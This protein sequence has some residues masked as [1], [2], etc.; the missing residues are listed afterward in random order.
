VKLTAASDL[1]AVLRAELLLAR[2]PDKAGPMQAY[3]KSAMPYLGIQTPELRAICTRLF[4]AHPIETPV[5]W[6]STCL[7]IWRE[8]RFREERY[9]AIGLTGFRLYRS[10]QTLETLAMYEEMIVTGAWWDFVDAIASKRLGALLRAY[11]GRMRTQMLKWSRCGD[12]WKR[13]S[14]ILCQLGF[15]GETDL[16]LLYA[17]IEP[18]LSSS[19]L[20]GEFFLQ[21]AIGWA[22]RQYAWTDAREVARY[23]RE[24]QGELSPL[25]KREA[26]KN[27]G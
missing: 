4:A 20:S 27:I 8:A 3:M 23:V 19:P 18:S 5:A 2:N 10:F 6:R 25:S 21:K 11:P 13:R 17:C 16:D 9:A 15:K 26:L 14:A 1:R 12:L 22:L 7:G 24:H